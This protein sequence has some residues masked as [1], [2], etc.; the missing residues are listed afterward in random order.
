L[1][2]RHAPRLA[3]ADGKGGALGERFT[4]LDRVAVYVPGGRG[5]RSLHALM[6]VTLAQAPRVPEIVRLA[7][8][9]EPRTGE[10]RA[11]LRTPGAGAH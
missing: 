4:A 5:G 10:P 9:P 1:R 6:T 7:R 11:P 3:H 8:Q 2:G